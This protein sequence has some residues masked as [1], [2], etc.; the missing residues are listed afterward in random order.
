MIRFVSPILFL[1]VFIFFVFF[2]LFSFSF[3]HTN[4]VL[5][6]FETNYVCLCM[7]NSNRRLI[8]VIFVNRAS[9]VCK[10]QEWECER[11][12]GREWMSKKNIIHQKAKKKRKKKYCEYF[13]KW[14]FRLHPFFLIYFIFACSK[15]FSFVS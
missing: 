7:W 11:E 4:L 9:F 14:L 12:K 13:K 8:E 2:F 5:C 15:Y 3:T 10:G 1:Y 6:R